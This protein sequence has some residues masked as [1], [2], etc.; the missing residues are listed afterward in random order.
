MQFE[1][2]CNGATVG[3]FLPLGGGNL[4]Q[5]WHKRQ[6]SFPGW[7]FG[8]LNCTTRWADIP[9]ETILQT[10]LYEIQVKCCPQSWCGFNRVIPCPCPPPLSYLRLVRLNSARW[11]LRGK[12][13]HTSLHPASAP[14]SHLDNKGFPLLEIHVNPGFQIHS[15]VETASN[16]LFCRKNENVVFVNNGCGF[17]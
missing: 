17:D 7:T 10:L 15:A 5:V 16:L 4:R 9:E 1:Q 12:S 8:A 11:S 2:V 13:C 3:S 6:V 14:T